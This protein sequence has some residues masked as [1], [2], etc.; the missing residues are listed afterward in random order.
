MHPVVDERSVDLASDVTLQ[1][2][3]D[4]SLGLSLGRSLARYSIVGWWRQ[5]SLTMTI[6]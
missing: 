1:A 3:D 4:L 6:R 2:P 5:P